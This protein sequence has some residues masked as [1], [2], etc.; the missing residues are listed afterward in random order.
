LQLRR[1]TTALSHPGLSDTDSFSMD[2]NPVYG[3]PKAH[4]QPS[5]HSD[6]PYHSYPTTEVQYYS[7]VGGNIY[8]APQRPESGGAAPN[9]SA[10]AEYYENENMGPGRVCHVNQGLGLEPYAVPATMDNY[11]SDSCMDSRA[12]ERTEYYVNE[13]MG[14]ETQSQHSTPSVRV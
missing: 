2:H 9:L 7:A 13:G 14:P 12:T 3:M 8:A 5:P 10:R 1:W 4:T 6:Q 11:V